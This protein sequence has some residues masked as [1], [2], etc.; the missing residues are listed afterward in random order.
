MDGIPAHD[1]QRSIDWGRT[2]D[3]Y[4]SFRPGYP[5]SFYEHLA[6]LGV[7]MNGLRVLDLGCGTGALSLGLARRGAHVTG[8]DIAVDQVQAARDVAAGAGLKAHFDVR[9]AEDTGLPAGS[10]D[11]VTASQCW[12]YFDTPR[13]L[14]EV[15][16]VTAPGGRLMTC[17][18][19]W[20][21]RL[22][23]IARSSEALVLQHNSDWGGADWPGL[24]AAKPGWTPDDF[25]FLGNFEYDEGLSFT[26]ESWRGR[27]RACRGIGATLNA[28]EVACFDAQHAALLQRTAPPR[29][30][31]LHRIDAHLL[32]TDHT[33][34]S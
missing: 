25:P 20:L 2:S 10:F 6:A 12:L 29:F 9:P 34:G 30:E 26:H 7:P 18:L 17:H 16:R 32:G 28:E 4:A 31:V 1:G 11:L 23:S 13:V 5:D 19:C 8:V 22:D 14:E 24:I 33:H 3:D 21:P 27:I 15:R